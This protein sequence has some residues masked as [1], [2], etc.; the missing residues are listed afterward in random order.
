MVDSKYIG[1]QISHILH[2]FTLGMSG[3]CG[4][5]DLM[6]VAPHR[7]A[8]HLHFGANCSYTTTPYSSPVDN[9]ASKANSRQRYRL[10]STGR[11]EFPFLA[12]METCARTPM[13]TPRAGGSVDSYPA[14]GI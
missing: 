8:S 12:A 6:H 7:I 9:T 14:L 5:P 4:Y 13:L 10:W 1:Q 2:L 11:T 3:V